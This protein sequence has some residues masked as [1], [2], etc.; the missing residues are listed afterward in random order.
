MSDQE[1]KEAATGVWGGHLAGAIC[2]RHPS[3]RPID[4]YRRALGEQVEIVRTPEMEAGLAFEPGLLRILARRLDVKLRRSPPKFHTELPWLRSA[5]DAVVQSDG[6]LASAKWVGWYNARA[7]GRS[8]SDDVPAYVMIQEHVYMAIE[9]TDRSHVIACVSGRAPGYWMVPF[10]E[11]LWAV[12][13]DRL[14]AFRAEH[15]ER[16]LP[17]PPDGSASFDRY[18][19][20]E[21]K[22]VRSHVRPATLEEI[23]LVETLV[24]SAALAK[25]A[26]LAH[27]Q[28]RAC[29][30]ED[31]GIET[32]MGVVSFKTAKNGVRTLRLPKRA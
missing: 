10:R 13:R 9:G 23:E 8:E 24:E 14:E 11:K 25:A 4:A 31:Q 2:R 26:D 16:R 7:W 15:V 17:P 6:A 32:P 19:R 5:P 30:G 18:I 3:L 27:Q 22:Q 12:I 29:I 21:V 20:E 28:L 1:V